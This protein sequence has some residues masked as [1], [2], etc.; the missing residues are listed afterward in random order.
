MAVS[1]F[2]LTTI[3]TARTL[4]FAE[5]ARVMD[6]GIQ[7]DSYLDALED[8]VANKTTKTNL[9]FTNQLLT[10]LYC[11]EINDL[12]FKCFKH[13]WQLATEQEQPILALLYALGNDYLLSESAVVVMSTPL[14]EKVAVEKLEENLEQYHPGRFSPK[15]RRSVAQNIAS[16]WKQAGFITGK[17]KNIRTQPEVTYLV[18]AFALLLA[19]L[20]GDRGDFM[21]NSKWVKALGIGEDKVRELAFEAAKRDYLQ[22]QS[23]GEVTTIS[24]N[25]LLTQ[26]GIDG[27]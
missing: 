25:N 5:L 3:H 9:K 8:N 4:M 15:T 2:Q 7:D 26:L 20:H 11:F 18:T 17:V 21:L 23:A 10:R 22:Y 24:F 12:A 14:G 27:I 16:S 19:Y 1:S 6:H 13:F